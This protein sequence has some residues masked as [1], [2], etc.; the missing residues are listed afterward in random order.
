MGIDHAGNS[1]IRLPMARLVGRP[2]CRCPR[3]P[4]HL[5]LLALLGTLSLVY[6]GLH[7]RPSPVSHGSDVFDGDRRAF[8]KT[9]RILDGARRDDSDGP[10]AADHDLIADVLP[11]GDAL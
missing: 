9:R 3:V 2:H 5:F 4:C 1:S 8:D 11:Q 7:T 10:S 6:A